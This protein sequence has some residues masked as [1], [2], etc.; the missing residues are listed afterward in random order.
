[1][2][3]YGGQRCTTN[4][5]KRRMREDDLRTDWKATVSRWRLDHQ[6]REHLEEGNSEIARKATVVNKTTNVESNLDRGGKRV[7]KATMANGVP[8]TSK[9]MG[10]GLHLNPIARYLE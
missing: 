5:G 8:S 6:H 9:A 7:W 10:R 4:N 2:E 1:V 3:S